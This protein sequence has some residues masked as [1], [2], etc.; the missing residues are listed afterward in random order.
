MIIKPAKSVSGSISTPGDKS[1]SHRAAFV[2]AMAE[3]ES[4]IENFSAGEDCASTL[5]CLRQLGV[6]IERNGT[7]VR[8]RGVGKTGFRSSSEPLD[9]GNSGTTMRLLAGVLAG[10]SFE[11]VMTGDESLRR[12]PM[13][14]VIEPLR[15][16]GAE[17]ESENGFAPLKIRGRNPLSGI[18][19]ETPI[20]SAQVKSCILLAGINAD[21]G[22]TV[23]ERARTRDHTELMLGWFGADVSVFDEELSVSPPLRSGFCLDGAEGGLP[24]RIQVLGDSVLT[25]REIEIPGDISSAAFF[26]V[27]AACLPGSELVLE[28]IGINPTRS[29]ILSKLEDFGADVDLRAMRNIRY[30][31]SAEI[32]IRGRDDLKGK[33]GANFIGDVAQVIDEVPILAVLGTQM[34]AGIEIR[35]AAELRVKESDRIASIIK[36]LTR[37]NADVEEFDDGFRVGKSQLR[38]AGVDSFGDHRIA[39]AFA[40]AGLFAEGNTTIINPECADISFPGFYDLLESVVQ[41]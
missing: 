41:R 37:M 32:V 31:P 12:R 14:R 13:S 16:M 33:A 27:A 29:G 15:Q 22:T 34:E 24:N 38:G 36:N 40:I 20:A 8:V 19:Y 30:E 35:G 11:S 5:R 2:A 21:G 17:I 4:F 28:N 18:R 25:A 10:Q 26:I 6:E 39:M 23:T 9:C 1:I 7:S 3:G